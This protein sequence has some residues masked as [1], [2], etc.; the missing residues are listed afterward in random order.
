MAEAGA[1][2]G[3]QIMAKAGAEKNNFGSAT[4]NKILFRYEFVVY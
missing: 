3:A 1:G 2:A 4:L